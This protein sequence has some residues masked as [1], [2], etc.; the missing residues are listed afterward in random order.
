MYKIIQ[1]DF[2]N[3]YQQEVCQVAYIDRAKEQCHAAALNYVLQK[4]GLNYLKRKYKNKFE[5]KKGYGIICKETAFSIKCTIFC[6]E[7]NGIIYSGALQK[8]IQFIAV[9]VNCPAPLAYESQFEGNIYFD[10]VLEQLKEKFIEKNVL[11]NFADSSAKEHEP[12]P[13]EQV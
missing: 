13:E 8:V 12:E 3:E 1:L 5:I 9:K 2:K 10:Q 11:H 4:E 7:P 6:K